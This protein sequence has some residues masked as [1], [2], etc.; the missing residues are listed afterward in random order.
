MSSLVGQIEVA[1]I[2][3]MGKGT[4]EEPRMPM[5]KVVRFY[6]EFIMSPGSAPCKQLF[7][8]DGTALRARA[9]RYINDVYMG[10]AVRYNYHSL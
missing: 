8:A 9:S 7:D 4:V 10:N 3:T 1:V 5:L 2:A 6:H